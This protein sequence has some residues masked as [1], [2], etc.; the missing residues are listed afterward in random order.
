VASVELTGAGRIGGGLDGAFGGFTGHGVFFLS[1]GSLPTARIG[2]G[3][4]EGGEEQAQREAFVCHWEIL[5]IS[6][7]FVMR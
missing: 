2:E 5:A 1:A 3:E 4:G 7:R 6:R